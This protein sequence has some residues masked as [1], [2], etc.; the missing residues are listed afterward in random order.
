MWRILQLLLPKLC[1]CFSP[2]IVRFQNGSNKWQLNWVECNFGLK[3]YLWFQIELALRARSILKSRLWFHI[4][5]HSTQF[6][7][8]YISKCHLH[9]WKIIL[10]CYVIMWPWFSKWK[11]LALPIWRLELIINKIKIAWPGPLRNREFCFTRI[12]TQC[13]P[14]VRLGKHCE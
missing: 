13:F 5:L 8:H 11:T 9:G 3:S 4:K 2:K 10:S 14:R 12:S 7:Y 1:Y 6:N